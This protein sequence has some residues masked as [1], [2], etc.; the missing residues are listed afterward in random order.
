MALVAGVSACSTDPQPSSAAVYPGVTADP[1]LREALPAHV[2]Q[3]GQLTIVTDPTYPPM[4]FVEGDAVVGADI[5]LGR[6]IAAKFGLT[7]N[8]QTTAFSNVVPSVA[9]QEFELGMAALWAD[10]PEAS[11]ANMV[12]YFQAGTQVAIRKAEQSRDPADGF[13]GQSVAVEEGTEYIDTLVKKSADC[14]KAGKPPIDIRP[15][16]SQSKASKLLE[17]GKVDAMVGDSPTVQYTVARSNGEIVAIGAPADIRPYGIAVSP[18]YPELTTA[19]QNALEQLI[20]SGV[21]AEILT[22]WQVQ[23]GAITTPQVL[24]GAKP[25][26]SA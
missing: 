11:L 23:Q 21:Y 15:A 3:D 25:A 7:P 13:C 6:A 24:F 16:T 1:A 9:I 20:A 22:R 18:L 8:F 26:R 14:R 17:D 2:K 10:N 4:E 5:D 12:T 19:T